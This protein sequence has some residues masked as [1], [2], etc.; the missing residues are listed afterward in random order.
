[1]LIGFLVLQ[2]SSWILRVGFSGLFGFGFSFIAWILNRLGIGL[3]FRFSLGYGLLKTDLE[4]SKKK[5]LTDTGFFGFGRI[6][7]NWFLFGYWTI[8]KSYQSTS[9][10]KVMR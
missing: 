6:L 3:V 4:K 9:V 7:D 1:M 2:K 5:K 8:D 10:S